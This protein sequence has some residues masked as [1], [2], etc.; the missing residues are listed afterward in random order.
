MQ[1]LAQL[2]KS[3]PKSGL[4]RERLQTAGNS[5]EIETRSAGVD[6]FGRPAAGTA[7]NFS[8]LSRYYF[9]IFFSM[10]LIWSMLKNLA[11]PP[12]ISAISC[13]GI[14]TLVGVP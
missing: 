4:G 13:K 1:Q 6:D 5:E 2:V 10:F 3:T 12:V 9:L 11:L 14:L 7:R 8:G